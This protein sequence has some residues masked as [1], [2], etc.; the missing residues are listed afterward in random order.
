VHPL[1][2][3]LFDLL[4]LRS[5][6]LGYGDSRNGEPAPTSR[7]PAAVREAEKVERLRGTFATLGPAFGCVAAELDKPCLGRV[8][9]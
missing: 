6:P 1:T 4:Q 8:Q 5:H 9:L 2:K 3:L 7:L